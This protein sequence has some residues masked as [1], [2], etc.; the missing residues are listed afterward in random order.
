MVTK[1]YTVTANWDKQT[2]LQEATVKLHWS[3]VRRKHTQKEKRRKIKIGDYLL[4]KRVAELIYIQKL[5]LKQKPL[6]F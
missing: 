2:L 5:K 1:N 3:L 6:K 4:N